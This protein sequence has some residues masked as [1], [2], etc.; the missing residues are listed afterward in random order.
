MYLFGYNRKKPNKYMLKFKCEA[1]CMMIE[2]GLGVPEVSRKLG[3]SENQLCT[4]RKMFHVSVFEY[5]KC[6]S[7]AIVVSR[8]WAACAPTCTSSRIIPTP[9]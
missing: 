6:F 4:W 8:P 7:I 2:D 9:A 5:E 1:V 3:V